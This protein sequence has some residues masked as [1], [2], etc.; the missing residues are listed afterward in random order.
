MVIR[1]RYICT[2]IIRDH[3]VIL[4]DTLHV[5]DLLLVLQG[6]AYA[7]AKCMMNATAVVKLAKLSRLV[8]DFTALCEN[9]LDILVEAE[10]ILRKI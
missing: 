6:G 1:Y 9:T 2:T 8:L 7:L 3:A 10:I 5:V 4:S